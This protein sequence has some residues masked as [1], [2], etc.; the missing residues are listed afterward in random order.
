[1]GTVLVVG[2]S[3]TDVIRKEG[4]PEKRTLAGAPFNVARAIERLGDRSRIDVRLISSRSEKNVAIA[5]VD[6]EGKAT[7]E[8]T[9]LGEDEEKLAPEK[10]KDANEISGFYAGS[11]S[12]QFI[13]SGEK[14][15][16][17][18]LNLYKHMSENGVLT[19]YDP[20]IRPSIIPSREIVLPIVR[21]YARHSFIVKSSDEDLRWLY[22]ESGAGE[23]SLA[24]E[25]ANSGARAVVVTRGSEP[26][27]TYFD[28]E[29]FYGKKV[30]PTKVVDTVGAGD[31]FMGALMAKAL[32][33]CKRAE[34]L[35]KEI[36]EAAVDFATEAAAINCEREGA[37]PPLAAEVMDRIAER[38]KTETKMQR[39]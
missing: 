29:F 36:L 8:F 14:K 21:E 34:D 22:G 9:Y 39:R 16:L 7:Y 13:L 5:N 24:N 27:I 1:M 37:D 32:T 31:T 18:I 28:G 19:F 11:L 6:S 12:S 17:P 15:Y 10:F 25:L 38:E 4:C 35:T 2:E 33:V 20:N 23:E 3:L 26:P 30:R